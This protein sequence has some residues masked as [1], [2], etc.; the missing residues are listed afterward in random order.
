LEL[1]CEKF[2]R[3]ID[4]NVALFAATIA[5]LYDNDA[6]EAVIAYK[7]NPEFFKENLDFS[8]FLNILHRFYIHVQIIIIISIVWPM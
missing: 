5:G 1:G 8:R 7:P 2:A 4:K 6:R 3:I